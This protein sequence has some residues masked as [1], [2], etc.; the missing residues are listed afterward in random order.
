MP[1][2]IVLS[3]KIAYMSYKH[4]EAGMAAELKSGRKSERATTRK[5]IAGSMLSNRASSTM[6]TAAATGFSKRVSATMS[7]A[8]ATGLIEGKKGK[9]LSGRV[10]ETLF[11]AAAA[12]SG[13][14]GTELIDYALAKVALEDDFADQLLALKGSIPRDV[15]LGA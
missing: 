4:M 12:K 1:S 6:S 7:A 3:F 11:E 14:R 9:Q 13:L 10:H 5:G 8:A 2:G 15:D